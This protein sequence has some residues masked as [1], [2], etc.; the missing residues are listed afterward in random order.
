MAPELRD[1]LRW[2]A[3]TWT[4]GRR[5]WHIIVLLATL[6]V[7]IGFLY[8]FSMC[9]LPYTELRLV[10]NTNFWFYRNSNSNNI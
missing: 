3:T 7:Y 4:R 2:P 1:S 9:F 10:L 6:V 5:I 8:L